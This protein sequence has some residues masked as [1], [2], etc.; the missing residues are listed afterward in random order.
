MPPPTGVPRTRPARAAA[1]AVILA[2]VLLGACGGRDATG[3]GD[4]ALLGTWS[5]VAF[6]ERPLPAEIT[7]GSV[8]RSEF[9]E[10]T[11]VLRSD[12]T[13][14]RS[15]TLRRYGSNGAVAGPDTLHTLEGRFTGRGSG[16]TFTVDFGRGLGWMEFGT[17]TVS[18]T[19]LVYRETWGHYTGVYT[20]ER[21]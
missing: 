5:L 16:V 1:A 12:R 20:Y 8:S 14:A 4:A 6:H 7:P 3:P 17:A 11:L 10:G 9:R 21:R 15:E 13:F 18:G 2:A 19:R